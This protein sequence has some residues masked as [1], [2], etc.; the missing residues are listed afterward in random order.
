MDQLCHIDDI[1]NE[2]PKGLMWGQQS[3]IAI[4][5]NG[6]LHLYLNRC[7]HRGIPL[8]WLPDQFLDLERQFIQC[9]THGALF[10]IE[11]G[12][13]IQGPCQGQSLEPIRYTLIDE[14]ICIASS[15][16]EICHP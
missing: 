7:P 2:Q 14:M 3:L 5:W 9:S 6:Q 16:Q 8:E 4:K 11:T 13:C 10:Q 12:E 1:P 15:P